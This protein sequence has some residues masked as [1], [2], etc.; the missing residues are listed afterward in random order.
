MA[1]HF[2][3][4]DG[5]QSGHE[6]RGYGARLRPSDIEPDDEETNGHVQELARYLMLVHKCSPMAVNGNQT[7][8]TRTAAEVAP[9]P[10]CDGRLGRRE[11]TIARLTRRRL[12]V[13]RLRGLLLLDLGRLSVPPGRRHAGH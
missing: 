5:D 8:R 10:A 1:Q 9:R 12:A 13:Q 6:P 4:R 3:G 2:G 7:E 11:M